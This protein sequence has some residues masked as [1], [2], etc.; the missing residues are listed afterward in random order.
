MGYD[1]ETEVQI[2]AVE[3]IVSE[4]YK[5][6]RIKNELN[7]QEKILKEMIHELSKL[8]LPKSAFHDEVRRMLSQVVGKR[9]TKA[10]QLMMNAY[11]IA[12][13]NLTVKSAFNPD[14]KEY[15]D[16]SLHE[17]MECLDI[18]GDAI[19]ENAKLLVSSPISSHLEMTRE[20]IGHMM[21]ELES[22]ISK[23]KD[24][25][26]DMKS[27]IDQER[28]NF[29]ARMRYI[30]MIMQPLPDEYRKQI[31]DMMGHTASKIREIRL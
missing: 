16:M 31:D 25:G 21:N 4:F 28:H 29:E 20:Q 19:T 8:E 30:K 3:E 14:L 27:A 1:H 15:I 12:I 2:K 26:W 13:S 22:F 9:I 10:A 7:E 23:M 17:A 11:M 24:K 6:K 18:I 5:P